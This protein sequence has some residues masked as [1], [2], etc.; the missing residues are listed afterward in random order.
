MSRAHEIYPLRRMLERELK[1]IENDEHNSETLV[2]YYKVKSTQVALATLYSTLCKLRRLSEMLNMRFEDATITDIENLHFAIC[3]QWTNRNTR[4]K[5]RILLKNF[6]RWLDGCAYDEY[7]PRVKWIRLEKVPYIVVTPDDMISFQDGLRVCECAMNLRDR[8]LFSGKLDAGCRI[9]E[10]LPVR[11]GEVKVTD[12]GAILSSDGKTGKAPIILTWSTPNIVQWLN[13]HP[14]KD[15]PEA[16]LFPDLTKAAPTQLSYAGARDA[17]KECVKRAGIKKRV[18]LHLFKHVSST[19]DAAN[20]MPDSFRRYKHHWTPNSKMPAVYEHLSQEIVP[21]I[22]EE[23]WKKMGIAPE[24][25]PQE[26]ESHKISVI[27]SCQR[28]KAENPRDS[29]Y[30][31][32]CGFILDAAKANKIVTARGMA[33]SLLDQLTQDPEKLEKLLALIE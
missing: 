18:W 19:E 17:F 14:F 29:K 22:Q 10:I 9:G 16:P 31:N 23:A 3:Q 15:T 2:R 7:P 27:Q 32:R 13:N 6:Y 1:N 25:A 26:S 21:K 8:A 33:E 20:G 4:N 30:C 12:Q 5:Y 28:C 24:T 11:V